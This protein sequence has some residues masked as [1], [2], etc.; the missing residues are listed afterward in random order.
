MELRSS[1][2]RVARVSDELVEVTKNN[3]SRMKRKTVNQ[4]LKFSVNEGK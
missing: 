4:V 1:G 2:N 3:W